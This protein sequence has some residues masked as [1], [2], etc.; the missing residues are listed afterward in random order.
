MIWKRYS[1]YTHLTKDS[2]PLIFNPRFPWACVG[3]SGEG[4]DKIDKAI[5]V[6]YLP[7]DE[8][9][10]MYWNDAFKIEY[11]L[12]EEIIFTDAFPQPSW[13]DECETIEDSHTEDMITDIIWLRDTFIQQVDIEPTKD[14]AYAYNLCDRILD[15]LRGE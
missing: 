7:A 12:E 8:N 2:R 3:L 1:F 9:L 4:S 14:E 5:M 11:T 10:L 15:K 13:F 6:A